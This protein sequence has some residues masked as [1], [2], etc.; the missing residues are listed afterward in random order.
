MYNP[1]AAAGFSPYPMP[2]MAPPQGFPGYPP[3]PQPPP[4]PSGTHPRKNEH[5]TRV[6]GQQRGETPPSKEEQGPDATT[7]PTQSVPPTMMHPYAQMTYYPPYPYLPPYMMAPTVDHQSE[8][9]QGGFKTRGQNNRIQSESNAKTRGNAST[10]GG[11]QPQ[12]RNDQRSSR[13]ATMGP[14]KRLQFV[15]P[16][17][18][19]PVGEC[20]AFVEITLSILFWFKFLC[21]SCFLSR[22]QFCFL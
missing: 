12:D 8:A 11:G 17:T 22:S 10:P 16:E 18:L 9:A 2:L 14:K 3:M 6:A 4:P 1:A 15:N 5:K 7:P 19:A 21:S 13:S 20:P